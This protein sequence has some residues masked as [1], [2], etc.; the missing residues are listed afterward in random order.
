[1]QSTPP[2]T[3]PTQRTHMQDE[4]REDI[5]NILCHALGLPQS[6]TL[7]RNHFA[8]STDSDDYAACERMVKCGYM[9]KG[10]P[11]GYGDYFHCT[12]DGVKA[13]LAAVGKEST[14]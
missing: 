14:P 6:D 3:Q 8:A 12:K 1:M 11:L 13:A 2:A 4:G 7:Y 9:F 5:E 10:Q